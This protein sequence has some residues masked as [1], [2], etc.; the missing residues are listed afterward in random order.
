MPIRP[1]LTISFSTAERLLS[2][3]HVFKTPFSVAATPNQPHFVAKIET[4]SA[5]DMARILKGKEQ[6]VKAKIQF[7]MIRNRK[8]DSRLACPCLFIII[9]EKIAISA[10]MSAIMEFFNADCKIYSI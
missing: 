7:V 5:S 4:I 9:V 10:T 1:T 6:K 8:V 3:R 2:G